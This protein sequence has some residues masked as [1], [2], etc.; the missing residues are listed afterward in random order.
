MHDAQLGD[1]PC[2]CVNGWTETALTTIL[3]MTFQLTL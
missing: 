1:V 3:T 2:H